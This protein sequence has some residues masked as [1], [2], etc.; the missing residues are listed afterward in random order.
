MPSDGEMLARLNKLATLRPTVPLWDVKLEPFDLIAIRWA[1]ARIAKLE[2]AL[3]KYSQHLL[4]CT[5]WVTPKLSDDGRD[6]NCGLS[7]ALAP[8]KQEAPD[9]RKE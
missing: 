9:A 6:C 4:W 8:Y 5:V 2:G 1:V 3:R 7:A